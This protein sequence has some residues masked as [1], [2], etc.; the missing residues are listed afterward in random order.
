MS[1]YV[2]KHDEHH[3]VV[4]GW[5]NPLQTFFAQV[6]DLKATEDDLG[7]G[8]EVMLVW[9]GTQPRQITD[10]DKLREFVYN[11]AV[12]ESDVRQKLESDQ[13]NAIPPTPLQQ[14]FIKLMENT[15]EPA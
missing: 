7:E 8:D 15:D 4:V 5:D 2:I 14:H 12:I 6:Y 11:F 1:R 10:I 9:V 3:E 13:L